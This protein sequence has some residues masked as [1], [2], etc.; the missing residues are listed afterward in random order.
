[1]KIYFNGGF[2]NPDWQADYEKSSTWPVSGIEI[3][4]EE[5]TSL[6]RAQEAGK[7]IQ[8]DANGHPVP[9]EPPP[10]T[11]ADLIAANTATIQAQLDRQAQLKGYDNIV[12]ACSYAAQEIGAPFQAEGAAY[13]A[14]RSAV[15]AQAYATLA[16]VEAGEIPMPTPEEAVA[17]MP[18]L[19]LP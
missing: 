12:S 15:W 11:T 4:D 18:A 6:L 19:V 14:W 5:Y 9:V 8:P 17:A 3:S 16:Q 2:Y 1:M 7:H 10:P 13:L